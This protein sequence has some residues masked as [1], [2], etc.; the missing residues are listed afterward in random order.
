[1]DT[2]F[3]KLL[4]DDTKNDILCSS[5]YVKFM[6]H[7]ERY[8]DRFIILYTKNQKDKLEQDNFQV[9]GYYDTK[10]NIIY[11]ASDNIKE[12][13]NDESKIKFDNFYSL[14]NKIFKE[15]DNYVSEYIM[16]N[17]DKFK[18]AA[19]EQT[20][21]ED[22]WR[23]KNYRS[24]VEREFISKVSPNIMLEEINSTYRL[25]REP[26]YYD[27][28][29]LEEYLFEPEKTIEKY[30]NILMEKEIAELGLKILSF[31]VKNEYLEK[32]KENKDNKYSHIYLN[33]KILDSLKPI[34]ARNVNI[35]IRYGDN[36]LVFKYDYDSLTN[37][38]SS[39]ALKTNS[40]GQSYSRVRN[41]F[42]DNDIRK[43]DGRT[44]TE[45]SF[46]NIVSIT[47][48]KNVLYEKNSL[49]KNIEK[50]DFEEE[51]ER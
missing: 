23:I 9:S 37:S 46:S 20:N 31:E 24:E 6:L 28:T 21:Y 16:N 50:D 14:N 27:K 11:N 15:I 44:E 32:I 5:S 26:Y 38:L 36:E 45:F 8:K 47:H 33:K 19:I 17:P 3:E 13:L 4:N 49:E 43:D 7:K 42:S 10:E 1:M 41:F 30:A 18:D 51:L 29:L 34:D 25:S 2:N 12:L 22:N 35:K 39:G 48:G 40:Y